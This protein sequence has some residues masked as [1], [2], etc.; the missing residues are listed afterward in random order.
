MGPVTTL[1]WGRPLTHDD[2][3]RL[4]FL[5]ARA[6]VIDGCLVVS[7]DDRSFTRDDLA[8]MPEDGHRYELIDGTILVTPAPTPRHQMVSR[9]VFLRLDRACPAHLI[10]LYAPL[11][12]ALTLDTVLQPDLLVARRSD[13]DTR[14]LPVP[15]LLAVEILS[16]STRRFDLD[17]KRARYERSGCPAYWVIDPDDGAFTAWEL[18][19]G[20]YVEVAHIGAGQSW[21]ATVPFPVTIAPAELI[22]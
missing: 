10:T 14:S 11:D 12:V 7:R 8:R 2:L 3:D 21:S 16:P 5:G 17:R 20:A 13:F 19:N 22:A 9:E 6:E 4:P 18:R 1:P 15:P